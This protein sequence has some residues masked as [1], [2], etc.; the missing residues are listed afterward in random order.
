MV[1]TAEPSPAALEVTR[2]LAELN[3]R[4]DRRPRRDRDRIIV[5]IED[6]SGKLGYVVFA[7]LNTQY[8]T[9]KIL[10][11]MFL[12]Q[13]NIPQGSR[14][15]IVFEGEDPVQVELNRLGYF[16][17]DEITVLL[18]P[19][20]KKLPYH[21]QWNDKL[22]HIINTPTL[23]SILVTEIAPLHEQQRKQSL[24]LLIGTLILF[25]VSV[26]LSYFQ[27]VPWFRKLE[28][29][30][31]KFEEGLALQQL[32][33]VNLFESGELGRVAALCNHLVEA[34]HNAK[35]SGNEAE[36][37]V[38]RQELTKN[39]A[40]FARMLKERDSF[41]EK[42]AESLKNSLKSM[43]YFLRVVEGQ[44]ADEE[45]RKLFLTYLDNE[46]L[47][48]EGLVKNVFLLIKVQQLEHVSLPEPVSIKEVVDRV[49][50]T[51]Q[52]KVQK[53]GLTLTLALPEEA[54]TI[55]GNKT[56]L[57]MI[58]HALV[59]NAIKF[60]DP[61]SE[62]ILGLKRQIEKVVLFV[63]NRGVV[64]SKDHLER[65][66]S[67]FFKADEKTEGHGLGLAIAKELIEHLGG[68][69]FCSSDSA[70]GTIFFVELPLV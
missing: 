52:E 9:E 51:V 23:S 50:A 8:I 20:A 56:S 45:K 36:V 4:F 7:V 30:L 16:R 55:S 18:G 27:V 49:Q 63:R 68:R 43:L 26:L 19:L 2:Y 28:L 61:E 57:V 62:I 66:F 41:T 32:D 48:T 53:R 15:F 13:A 31:S 38:L 29:L 10:H 47:K 12:K 24:Y 67:P 58:L 14:H 46:L 1:D 59:D 34:V 6:V 11:P 21:E 60:S 42:F 44:D 33:Q 39:K 70:N 3:E 37:E 65:V 35:G 17:E 25:A 64:L 69:I 22:V 5:P 54:G 40:S